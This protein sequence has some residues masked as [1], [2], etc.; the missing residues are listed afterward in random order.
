MAKVIVVTGYGSQVS[1][2]CFSIECP[3][4]HSKMT[5]VYLFEHGDYLFAMCSNSD[6]CEHMVLTQNPPGQYKR[7]RPNTLPKKKIFS[8][9][10]KGVSSSFEEIYNQAYCAEQLSLNQI[11]GTG[12]RKALEFLI[13]EYLIR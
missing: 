4:C 2:E 6:C 1:R 11:C 3:F 5:P 7:V 10:I 13:K 8:D 9:T 12:Y